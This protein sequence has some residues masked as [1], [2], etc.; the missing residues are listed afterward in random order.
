VRHEHGSTRCYPY[1]NFV[2]NPDAA[3][4]PLQPGGPDTVSGPLTTSRI[5][6]PNETTSATGPVT[7]CNREGRGVET[8]ALR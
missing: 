4:L 3:K 1:E 6:T 5:P 8:P 2:N 7:L